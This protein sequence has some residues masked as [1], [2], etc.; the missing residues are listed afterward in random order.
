MHSLLAQENKDPVRAAADVRDIMHRVQKEVRDE[1]TREMALVVTGST[2]AYALNDEHK[3]DFLEIA[4]ACKV[5]VCCRTTPLQK[6]AVVRLVKVTP[7]ERKIKEHD[8]ERDRERERERERERRREGELRSLPFVDAMP[9]VFS[10]PFSLLFL[11][12]KRTT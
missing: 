12:P 3:M 7:K 6:A 8:G 4:C 11:V 10:F 1:K 2:L 9:R 5:V